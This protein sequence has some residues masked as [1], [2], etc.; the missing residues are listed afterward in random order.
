MILIK[1]EL[2]IVKVNSSVME[3]PIPHDD[4]MVSGLH[5]DLVLSPFNKSTDSR[6]TLVDQFITGVTFIGILV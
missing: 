3:Q 1:P 5:L 4:G 2:T 6:S